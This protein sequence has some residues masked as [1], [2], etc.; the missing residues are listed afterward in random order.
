MFDGLV[1][2]LSTFDSNKIAAK[3]G[4]RIITYSDLLEQANIVAEKI[5][6]QRSLVLLECTPTIDWLITYV[7]ILVGKHV[8][9]LLPADQKQTIDYFTEIF[10]PNVTVYT[11]NRQR[12]ERSHSDMIPMNDDLCLMLSTSGSTG[13]P[14]CV[15]LSFE[16]LSANAESIVKYLDITESEVGTVNLPTNYSYGLSIVNS[17]IYAGATILF[18]QH[19]IVEDEFWEL[20]E[21]EKATSFAGVPYSYELLARTDYAKKIPPS[22]RYFSQAGGKLSSDKVRLFSKFARERAAKFFVMYGQTEAAPRISYLPPDM[23]EDNPESIGVPVPGGAL[24]IVDE[25]GEVLPRDTEG[26]LVYEGPNVM[27][28]YA[29]NISELIE[30]KKIFQLKTGD[31]AKQLSN[32]LFVI[33]G[34]KSRFIKVF[35]NR[36]S[37]DQIEVFCSQQGY[38]CIASGED[39][40]LVVLT[41]DEDNE[42]KISLLLSERLK[43]PKSSILV[44][45]AEKFPTLP[46]GKIDYKKVL[47]TGE[48]ESK[49]K[50][51]SVQQA[52]VSVFGQDASNKE[53]SF[54]DLGGDSLT[55]VKLSIELE[56]L[57]PE[58]PEDWVNKSIIELD[59]LSK[60][61]EKQQSSKETRTLNRLANADTLRAIVCVLV[62][63]F[64][65]FGSS[66]EFGLK[67]S[68]E[69]SLRSIFSVLD[70]I[71]MPLFTALA[72]MMFVAMAPSVTQFPSIVKNR[73]L[74]LIIPAFLVS[75]I[76]F[77][78]RTLVGRE[79]G[80][81]LDAVVHGYMHLWYLY[82]LFI[83]VLVIGSIHVLLKPSTTGYLVLMGVMF[84][85][86]LLTQN[87]DFFRISEAA[88]LSPYF[89]L[90]MLLFTHTRYLTNAKLILVGTLI[91]VIGCLMKLLSFFNLITLP[92]STK[93]LWLLVSL[94]FILVVYRFIPKI[95]AIQWIGIYTYAI[96]LWH[97]MANATV[98][99]VLEKV[100]FENVTVLFTV[101]LFCGLFVPIAMYKLSQVLP[102][103]LR[104]SLM[105]R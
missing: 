96:Y 88:R 57:I 50:A 95:N 3:D 83:M 105:G 8:P 94:S 70:L 31:I 78:L 28:G 85:L 81:F 63:A 79:S 98:R 103:I 38:T 9:I 104:Q 23:A 7:G 73:V 22:I 5:G 87:L 40:K 27:M 64:H 4:T 45:Y 33:T 100:G 67:I 58:L 35:G 69:S 47:I 48:P 43:L 34:R 37:L 49:I 39:E 19:S 32:G 92:D 54:T 14:K 77:V 25:N 18:N 84:Y 53:L 97:P 20:C 10:N 6:S 15:K 71:R 86:S 41:K 60:S 66:P 1:K 56:E 24:F 75:L 90:G 52:F 74:T 89:I 51:N 2:W 17:H 16:N 21:K 29:Q 13:S 76:Y 101:G 12:I 102:K 99:T 55:Y 46:N 93:P 65:V 11:S 82:A 91:T 80:D 26:E 61:V 44:L 36:I 42:E 30:N 72:G 68:E 62:V 59:R